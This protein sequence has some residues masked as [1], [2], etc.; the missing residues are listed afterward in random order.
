M[1][2]KGFTPLVLVIIIAVLVGGAVFAFKT[3][4][5]NKNEFGSGQPS[6]EKTTASDSA[7]TITPTNESTPTSK[8]AS[9]SKVIQPTEVVS[10]NGVLE[11]TLNG[12]EDAVPP[13]VRLFD[14]QLR[15]VKESDLGKGDSFT[16]SSTAYKFILKNIPPGKYLVGAA[17]NFYFKP[18]DITIWAGKTAAVALDKNPSSATITTTLSGRTYVDSNG[19]KQYDGGELDVSG[20]VDIGIYLLTSAG[21]KRVYGFS[22]LPGGAYN[23]GGTGQKFLGKYI[24]KSGVQPGYTPVNLEVELGIY[25]VNN[26]VNIPFITQSTYSNPGSI[27]GKV[28]VD[29]NGNGQYDGGESRPGS[30][31]PSVGLERPGGEYRYN[32][33]T[34]DNDGNYSFGNLSPGAYVVKLD[35]VPGYTPKQGEVTVNLGSGEEKAV[36]L[37]LTQR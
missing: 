34:V 10:A 25:N 26:I 16:R 2:E 30:Y 36:N 23:L 29:V 32:T 8:P 5:M 9:A 6:E 15:L 13:I 31:F 18:Q 19:N 27:K 28:Y 35:D 17:G 33:V 22:G 3:G 11:V 14:G 20:P 4:K 21:E 1:Q 37:S 12:P 24:F 7:K